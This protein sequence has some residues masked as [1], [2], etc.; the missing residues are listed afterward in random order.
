MNLFNRLGYPGDPMPNNEP[1]IAHRTVSNAPTAAEPS[2]ATR[3]DMAGPWVRNHNESESLTTYEFID[4]RELA[5]RLTVP[6]SWIRDQVRA[7]SEDHTTGPTRNALSPEATTPR[8]SSAASPTF[9]LAKNMIPPT[10]HAAPSQKPK[11]NCNVGQLSRRLARAIQLTQTNQ[12]TSR[13]EDW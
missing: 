7:R 4:S 9:A 8:N 10:T 5:R 1:A 2:D 6:T 12:A 11:L 13:E 3:P